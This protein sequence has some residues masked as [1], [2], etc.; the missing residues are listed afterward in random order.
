LD[1]AI[2]SEFYVLSKI[3]PFIIIIIIIIE[4]FKVA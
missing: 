4:I 1:P 2:H 3:F